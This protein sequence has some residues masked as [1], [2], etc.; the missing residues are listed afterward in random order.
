MTGVIAFP[1]LG[2][3]LAIAGMPANE[4]YPLLGYCGAIGTAVLVAASGG[5]KLITGLAE[6]VL[7]VSQ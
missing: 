6:L 1:V 4:I 5:R 2:T 7:R 3:V